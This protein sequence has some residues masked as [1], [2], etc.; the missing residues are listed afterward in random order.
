MVSAF[1]ATNVVTEIREELRFVVSNLRELRMNIANASS[2]LLVLAGSLNERF[3]A[4][5]VENGHPGLCQHEGCQQR[6]GEHR[7]C[8]EGAAGQA[9]QSSSNQTA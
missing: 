8:A 2:D 1:V 5:G 7:N 4:L 9:L 6:G 3:V